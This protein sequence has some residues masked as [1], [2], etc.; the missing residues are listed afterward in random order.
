MVSGSRKTRPFS[1]AIYH[2]DVGRIGRLSRPCRHEIT[3]CIHTRSKPDVMHRAERWSAPRE[4][5]SFHWITSGFPSVTLH[6]RLFSAASPVSAIER[7]RVSSPRIFGSFAICVAFS[8]R[9]YPCRPSRVPRPVY[10]WEN[11]EFNCLGFCMLLRRYEHWMILRISF[12]KDI[13]LK[14][15]F[16]DFVARDYWHAACSLAIK[17]LYCSLVCCSI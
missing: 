14:N 10:T 16:L 13:D 6:L 2:R 1:P 17:N 8:F 9:K 5:L 7:V 15:I 11:G 3:R 4:C 12:L